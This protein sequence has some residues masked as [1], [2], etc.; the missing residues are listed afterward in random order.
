MTISRLPFFCRK[1]IHV[2]NNFVLFG[3]VCKERKK[4]SRTGGAGKKKKKKQASR[5]VRRTKRNAF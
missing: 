4:V 2:D 3:S 1:I 5:Q